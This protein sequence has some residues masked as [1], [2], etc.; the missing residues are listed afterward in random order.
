MLTNPSGCV[1]LKI[2]YKD[3]DN[4][5]IIWNIIYDKKQINIFKLK[6]DPIK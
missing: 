2:R 5:S 4:G 6:D 1:R 3:L